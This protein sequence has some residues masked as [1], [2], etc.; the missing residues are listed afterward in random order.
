MA[1]IN[2]N[3]VDDMLDA[4]NKAIEIHTVKAVQGLSYNKSELAEVVDITERN[5]GKYIVWNGSTRYY[6]YSE[7][8]TYPIGTKVYV[9]IPNND[10]SAQKQIVGQYVADGEP[11]IFYKNPLEAYE[12]L[13]PNLIEDIVL[14]E[15]SDIYK[16]DNIADLLANW[17]LTKELEEE[18]PPLEQMVEIFR[19]E[20]LDK[21]EDS[22]ERE[23][24]D[25][26]GFKYM[27]ISADFKTMLNTFTPIAGD[28]GIAVILWGADRLDVT[29]NVEL[30]KRTYTLSVRDMI[31]NVYNYSSYFKQASL[32]DV[33]DFKRILKVIVGF[34]Q[35]G[36]FKDN[37]NHFI[38]V[39]YTMPK[40]IVNSET[41]EIEEIQEK[42]LLQPNLF[43]RN[44]SVQFGNDLINK[45]DGL[46]IY[47]INGE[48]YDPVQKDALNSKTIE[49][50]WTHLNSSTNQYEVLKSV[51]DAQKN[52]INEFAIHWY[53]DAIHSPLD[54]NANANDAEIAGEKKKLTAYDEWLAVEQ[55][56]NATL[57]QK[58]EAR[59]TLVG[60]YG[61]KAPDDYNER[62]GFALTPDG[63]TKVENARTN[64][65]RSISTSESI[66][67]DILAGAGWKPIE[68]AGHNFTQTNFLPDYTRAYSKV[69]CIIEY[70]PKVNGQ[71]DTT[72]PDYFMVK[73]NEIQFNN[74]R[75]TS[76]SLSDDKANALKITCNDGTDGNYPIYNGTDGSLLN[77]ADVS[78]I[79]E[80]EVSCFSL[81]TGE[82]YFNGN[83]I[84]IWKIP[85]RASMIKINEEAIKNNLLDASSLSIIT[86]KIEFDDNFYYIKRAS[87]SGAS[88]T[89]IQEYTIDQKYQREKINNTVFCYL[90]KNEE[91]FEG[92]K[93][94]L[95][96]QHGSS[97]TDYTFSLSFI[98]KVNSDWKVVGPADTAL[99]IGDENYL[100]IG[101]DLYN[102]KDEKVD[103]TEGQKNA[104]IE[105]WMDYLPEGYYSGLKI[106][107]EDEN[108]ISS[109][110]A[111][112]LEFLVDDENYRIAVRVKPAITDID[113]L[114]YIVLKAAVK[115]NHVEGLGEVKFEQLLPIHIRAAGTNW[116]LEGSDYIVYDD[117]GANPTCY[118]DYYILKGNDS[119][120]FIE[121]KSGFSIQSTDFDSN[122]RKRSY[123]PQLISF[124]IDNN[125]P[126]DYKLQTTPLYIEDISKDLAICCGAQYTCPLVI[127]KNKYQIPA[128][129]SWNGELTVDQAGNKIL[130]SMIGAGHKNDNNTFSGVL[131]GDVIQKNHHTAEN[132]TMTGLFGYDDGEQTFGFNTSGTA[133]IGKSDIGRIYVD[134]NT[135][136]ITSSQREQYDINRDLYEKAVATGDLEKQQMYNDQ[137]P[138]GTDINLKE[139]YI[140]I[141]GIGNNTCIHLDSR[142][143]Q[144][145]FSITNKNN[146][147]LLD[148]K[149]E[150]YYLQT[151]NYDAVNKSGLKLDLA[152]GVLNS[153]DKI[154]ING[155][156]GSSI[157]F[158][159]NENYIKL[160]ITA[161]NSYFQMNKK[162]IT[163]A[164]ALSNLNNAWNALNNVYEWNPAPTRNATTYK[165]TNLE[166][167]QTQVANI[168]NSISDERET[169]DSAKDEYN[170]KV[171]EKDDLQNELDSAILQFNVDSDQ[172]TSFLRQWNNLDPTTLNE[173]IAEQDGIITRKE[174]E[175]R[176]IED[177]IN[178]ILREKG[179]LEQN[180]I[181][182]QNQYNTEISELTAEISRLENEIT[183]LNIDI[184]T[185]EEEKNDL[186]QQLA[187]LE[188]GSTQYNE[189][190]ARY[191]A[192]LDDLQGYEDALEDAEDELEDKKG[193]LRE[194]EERIGVSTLEE[195][196]EDAENEYLRLLGEKQEIDD[197]LEIAYSEKAN[198]EYSLINLDNERRRL[199]R[200]LNEIGQRI[201]E[202]GEDLLVYNATTYN[203]TP[204]I[205][206]GTLVQE[207][208][209]LTDQI[210]DIDLIG[211]KDEI[212]E[213]EK[214]LNDL[215]SLRDEMNQRINNY[216]DYYNIYNSNVNGTGKGFI[217]INNTEQIRLNIGDVFTVDKDGKLIAKNADI[218]GNIN[219]ISGTL[220]NVTVESLNFKNVNGASGAVVNGI[221]P[222]WMTFVT[223]VTGSCSTGKVGVSA[224]VS[225]TVNVPYSYTAYDTLENN[226]VVVGV[227]AEGASLHSYTG[228]SGGGWN[229]RNYVS[230]HNQGTKYE[231]D[232]YIPSIVSNTYTK[233]ASVPY[234]ATVSGTTNVPVVK[235]ITL[236]VWKVNMW[237]LT[238]KDPEPYP[239]TVLDD[240]GWYR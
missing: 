190:Y 131:M 3:K 47:T 122:L 112:N 130:A 5:L 221:K 240:N 132:E 127:L 11:G 90:I 168:E 193:E 23:K 2:A 164:D 195:E 82:D 136:R 9:N 163:P 126:I 10:F 141:Q 235:S 196:I 94:L 233:T 239:T 113:K 49:S 110:N 26:Q 118:N 66:A 224:T 77:R 133:F 18:E 172:Y 79:R 227:N 91:V 226:H 75:M 58:Q 230:P 166:D 38:P 84:L 160:G 14:G 214:Y 17:D 187:G 103:L 175:L 203:W 198:Y 104:I 117:K 20:N 43:V 197:A 44:V 210:D 139:N 137:D 188:Y 181:D 50:Q 4:L 156:N 87:S 128:I 93:T 111:K 107:P 225:D 7:N 30:K 174:G 151:E 74:L 177:D 178:D 201:L 146:K 120:N 207:I 236:K 144:S 149:D 220:N 73:S 13:T 37:T 184:H 42:H 209:N 154:T 171:K 61:L 232:I 16:D 99:T 206:D 63:R 21:I 40:K 212:D 234:R 71:F 228:T 51:A 215:I 189:T 19:A 159:D 45:N 158:G 108:D 148:I 15:K 183:A 52:G 176:D 97:G 1:D 167:L 109:D 92:S 204:M 100:E 140:D 12:P 56:E 114:R 121:L 150:E 125:I 39:S 65:E 170:T 216:Q 41:G 6:A 105:A 31:G 219:A 182:L 46:R 153:Y 138:R 67:S 222:R 53:R 55:D 213:Q 179:E 169:L 28:Y 34:Y 186:E 57:D 69:L 161:G 81:A 134:G 29:E 185:K 98:Q 32:Y 231:V 208:A 165:L 70:G 95:F 60:S 96:N 116:V 199:A 64:I 237:A 102:S 135:G 147:I 157:N 155:A 59:L 129:N 200:L 54:Y 48:T 101:F 68:M 124:N 25:Y 83:E 238:N 162:S 27:G 192:V 88:P 36:N 205:S 173:L 89:K 145:Y 86:D 143:N 35:R 223:D 78:K 191:L 152:N 229:W 106:N 202:E 218:K 123:Y 180:L 62:D 76:N 142:P 115:Q 194:L 85:R 211:L 8:T 217:S 119:G 24:H 80:L 22:E 33:S 72:S